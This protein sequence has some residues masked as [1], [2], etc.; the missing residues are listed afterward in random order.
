L[1]SPA[2]G[3]FYSVVTFVV[4]AGA[5][6]L[7]TQAAFGWS[8]PSENR[9]Q[10]MLTIAWFVAA[11]LYAMKVGRHRDQTFGEALRRGAIDVGRAIKG[12]VMR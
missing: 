10:M 8:F 1:S 11:G 7:G 2:V 6:V 4:L 12:M 3:S 9:G 5:F